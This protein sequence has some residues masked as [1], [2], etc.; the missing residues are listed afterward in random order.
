MVDNM[1]YRS[2]RSGHR[3]DG[4]SRQR[5]RSRTKGEQDRAQPRPT[6]TVLLASTSEGVVRTSQGIGNEQ[7]AM[8]EI[9]QEARRRI[10]C[11]GQAAGS[12][13]TPQGAEHTRAA[14]LEAVLRHRMD[15]HLRVLQASGWRRG[16]SVQ[17][18]PAPQIP[19]QSA[20][21]EPAGDRGPPAGE[22]VNSPMV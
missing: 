3:G 11:Q 21:G 14:E 4:S 5:V 18:G 1:A 15:I 19:E 20:V 9:L 16:E 2:Q 6:N 17:A 10:G 12:R 8:E 7:E 22:A 13:E